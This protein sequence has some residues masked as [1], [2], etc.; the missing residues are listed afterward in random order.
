MIILD[1]S[2]VHFQIGQPLW[3][4]NNS[5]LNDTDYLGTMHNTIDEA[6]TNMH[7]LF[8]NIDQIIMYQ[9]MLSNLLLTTNFSLKHF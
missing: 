9:M 3:K 2:F 6:K 1:I 5:L 8:Y 7:C 4:Y